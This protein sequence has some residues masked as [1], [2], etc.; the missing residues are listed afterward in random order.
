MRNILLLF[1]LGNAITLYSKSLQT[2]VIGAYPKPSYIHLEDWFRSDRPSKLYEEYQ[3]NKSETQIL[4]DR[5]IKEAVQEQVALGID[6]PTDGEIP[7][8]HYIYYHCRHLNGIDFSILTKKVMREGAWI[9]QVPT[10]TGPISAQQPF[11][12]YDYHI[13]QQATNSPIKITIP[14]PLTI[15][16]SVADRYYF[17][18]EKLGIALATSINKEIK[19]L[20]DAGCTWIQ[21]DEPLFARYPEKA[22]KFGIKLLER[23]FDGVP[24]EVTTVVH[25]CCGYPQ[26]LDQENYMKADPQSYVKLAQALDKS[27]NIKALS[28]EDAHSRNNPQLF[29]LFTHKIIILG[30]IDISRSRVESI[31]EITEH[32]QDI[33]HYIPAERLMIAPDCGLT[34]L[35]KDIVY[36]KIKNMCAAVRSITT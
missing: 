8:E 14:G 30:V 13:A 35:P 32:I 4:F 22:L 33:L 15:M 36:K 18:E 20:V 19:A 17:D 21:I 2:T 12:T 10:I 34:M 1:L 23:C 9:A 5:A 27:T 29:S 11:L 6:I 3:K 7:R 31:D 26:Y 25:I 28:I 24:D 16:D